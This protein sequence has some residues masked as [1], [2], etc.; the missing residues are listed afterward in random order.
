M[1]WTLYNSVLIIFSLCLFTYS[2]CSNSYITVPPKK[3][4]SNGKKN[5]N[6]TILIEENKLLNTKDQNLMKN[7]TKFEGCKIK[8]G[9][10]NFLHKIDKKQKILHLIPGNLILNPKSISIYQNNDPK[11][12]FNSFD[13]ENILSTS[14]TFKGTNCFDLVFNIADKAKA[15]LN[16]SKLTICDKNNK[17]WM[18]SINEFKLCNKITPNDKINI[19]NGRK[20]VIEFHSINSLSKKNPNSVSGSSAKSD[21]IK[22]LYYDNSNNK[23]S[24]I[25]NAEEKQVKEQIKNIIST[26]K[27]KSI[28][29]KQIKR[30]MDAKL[31]EAKDLAHEL[32]VK[33]DIIKINI[34]KTE[35]EQKKKM[36]LIN[37]KSQQ[38]DKVSLLKAVN[39]KIK[40][41]KDESINQV[42]KVYKK[43]IKNEV[44]KATHN[45]EKMMNLEAEK[46]KFTDYSSCLANELLSKNIFVNFL[47]FKNK[48]YNEELC[49]K[50]FGES[51]MNECIKKNKFCDMCCDLHIGTH[52]FKKRIECKTGCGKI[53]NGEELK[54]KNTKKIKN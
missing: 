16:N 42:K 47:E 20:S 53:L 45:A 46:K 23:I 41:I 49:L 22:K 6:Y 24:K 31:K 14:Y 26:I 54:I 32:Q 5:E 51:G 44:S 1:K 25:N 13:L 35:E 12:L 18:N 34:A 30:Q 40:S 27:N 7:L 17:E 52:F 10:V 28:E 43:Q 48:T 39:E 11:T 33:K 8:Q 29:E 21:D 9:V 37:K 50:L 15:V 38:S 19:K 3:R 36:D 2:M 4:N